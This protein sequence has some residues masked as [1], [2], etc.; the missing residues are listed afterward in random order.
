ED[1]E[2]QGW[3]DLKKYQIS[4]KDV[5]IGIAASGSTPYVV[6]ALS[7]ARKK[8]VLTGCIVCNK[9]SQVAGEAE[10]PVEV[11]VGPEFVTGST[12]MK[13]GTAQKLVL[14][15]L[16]TSLMIKLGKVKG[17]KMI[18][19]EMHVDEKT[20]ERLLKKY[21]NVRNAIAAKKYLIC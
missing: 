11:I 10:F 4:S 16:S 12:R 15:M 5:L 6:G 21:G 2:K 18:M 8:G 1:D 13:S 14:N 17:N 3:K 9:N 20:A 7:N 19:N